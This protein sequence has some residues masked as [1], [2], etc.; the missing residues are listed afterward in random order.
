MSKTIIRP[1][2]FLIA[3]IGIAGCSTAPDV[4]RSN[5]PQFQVSE[6]SLSSFDLE[7]RQDVTETVNF[8]FDQVVL[9]SD[10][11]TYLN[12]QAEWMIEHY[13]IKFSVYGHTD[14]VGNMSY[15]MDLGMRRAETVIAYLV[16]RG[17]N[18]ARLSAMTSLGE[19]M[20][21]VETD[22]RNLENRRVTTFVNGVL[23]PAQLVEGTSPPAI[24]VVEGVPPTGKPPI[25]SKEKMD[26]GRGNGDDGGDPGESEGRNNGGDEV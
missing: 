11:K 12:E 6:R 20:P 17:V 5:A 2:I 23:D 3:L 1:I 15:N 8:D 14:K 9:S 21:V 26:A 10:A 16:S 13:F 25:E 7:F 4:S 24:P 19:E 22:L 18:G